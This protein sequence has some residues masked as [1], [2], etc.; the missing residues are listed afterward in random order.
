MNRRKAIEAMLNG[1]IVRPV[2]PLYMNH[3]RPPVFRWNDAT[4][5]IEWCEFPNSPA[6]HWKTARH[7]FYLSDTYEIDQP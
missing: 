6:T 2:R 1:A 7:S 5:A 4:Q 3:D